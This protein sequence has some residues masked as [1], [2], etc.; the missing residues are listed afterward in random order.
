MIAP[1]APSNG[2]LDH[3][4]HMDQGQDPATALRGAS[5]FAKGR[6]RRTASSLI[7]PKQKMT[8]ESTRPLLVKLTTQSAGVEVTIR[9]LP[10]AGT[11]L[12]ELDLDATPSPSRDHPFQH[13]YYWAGFYY[14]GYSTS[15]VRR[16][17]ER[18]MG[19]TGQSST[20]MSRIL[21]DAGCI[22][23]QRSGTHKPKVDTQGQK[24]GVTARAS[25][26]AGSLQGNHRMGGN[27]LSHRDCTPQLARNS[28]KP[29]ENH[30][31]PCA[32][33]RKC[34]RESDRAVQRPS[35]LIGRVT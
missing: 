7:S 34:L 27:F 23:P 29:P 20:A 15:T 16:P 19:Q 17:P 2:Q 25:A 18:R 26:A 32:P 35:H 10:K 31:K 4:L 24:R 8:A 21:A 1:S 12:T 22:A 14:S 28:R 9:H 5:K 11:L 33:R 6:P 13:P 3:D 30:T